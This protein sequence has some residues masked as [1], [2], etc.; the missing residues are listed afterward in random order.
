MMAEERVAV[1][2]PK[3]PRPRAA[4]VIA[5]C[6]IFLSFPIRAASSSDPAATARAAL[7][8]LLAPRTATLRAD[9]TAFQAV[10][11]RFEC[12][13]STGSRAE[14]MALTDRSATVLV[15]VAATATLPIT[16]AACDFPFNWLV[17]L[18]KSGREWQVERVW[19]P[20]S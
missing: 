18:R 16:H 13:Q 3:S 4:A 19:T 1:S 8:T 15:D 10:R 9:V 20:E 14:V 17:R 7:S 5:L 6:I 12:V 11:K 2:T